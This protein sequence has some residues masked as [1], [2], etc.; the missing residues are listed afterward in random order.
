MRKFF[1]PKTHRDI[2]RFLSSDA[3]KRQKQQDLA[4][5]KGTAA[6]GNNGPASP[7]A[8]G[9]TAAA[10]AEGTEAAETTKVAGAL[11]ESSKAGSNDKDDSSKILFDWFEGFST[12]LI[13]G[14]LAA[15]AASD[16]LNTN[17]TTTRVLNI[18]D[19]VL[20][21]FFTFE[22]G[23]R[24]GSMGSRMLGHDRWLLIDLLTVILSLTGVI[25]SFT[26]F[27]SDAV[28]FTGLRSIRLFKPLTTLR[29]ITR[30][31]V[32]FVA[33]ARAIETLVDIVLL[34]IVFLVIFGV[35]GVSQYNRRLRN[36]C[37][38]KDYF[39]ARVGQVFNG[40]AFTDSLITEVAAAPNTRTLGTA[41]VTAIPNNASITTTTAAPGST[42]S[43]FLTLVQ[44]Q[45]QYNAAGHAAD[46]FVKLS[47][48]EQQV[49][50]DL[51]P[52]F[53]WA[54]YEARSAQFIV[55]ELRAA[56]AAYAAAGAARTEAVQRM[57]ANGT[58]DV[59]RGTLTVL[60]PFGIVPVSVVATNNTVNGSI[61]TNTT[62]VTFSLRSFDAA[63]PWNDA[64]ILPQGVFRTAV[65][66]SAA[67]PSATSATTTTLS[68][69]VLTL[70]SA[71]LVASD[72]LS[73]FHWLAAF[74]PELGDAPHAGA[75]N[76][77]NLVAT[78]PAKLKASLSFRHADSVMTNIL[79]IAPRRV[80]RGPT[81]T[82]AGRAA[83]L[84]PEGAQTLPPPPPRP[85]IA[86]SGGSTLAAAFAILTSALW[87]NTSSTDAFLNRSVAYVINTTSATR[88]GLPQPTQLGLPTSIYLESDLS[89]NRAVEIVRRFIFNETVP[90][91]LVN[92]SVLGRITD[93]LNETW[94]RR[95]ASPSS[96]S[97][98]V[99]PWPMINPQSSAA[100]NLAQRMANDAG[101]IAEGDLF[102]TDRYF[103]NDVIFTGAFVLYGDSGGSPQLNSSGITF[104]NLSFMVYNTSRF[105]A[106]NLTG[107][108]TNASSA[109]TPFELLGMVPPPT[110]P[111]V[112]INGT[113][114]TTF[115][116]TST[117]TPTST[118][119]AT[120]T[121]P[122]I[123]GL[124]PSAPPPATTVAPAV[125]V[126][127]L[128]F[129]RDTRLI[130]LMV[131]GGI[132][133]LLRNLSVAWNTTT[134]TIDNP[135]LPLARTLPPSGVWWRGVPN[136]TIGA[137]PD[138][139]FGVPIPRSLNVTKRLPIPNATVA[140]P[141]LTAVA[142][143]ITAAHNRLLSAITSGSFSSYLSTLLSPKTIIDN[144]LPRFIDGVQG[145]SSK[146]NDTLTLPQ[147]LS[148]VGNGSSAAAVL[149]VPNGTMF[150]NRALYRL[151][152][153]PGTF[154]DSDSRKAAA[155]ETA[156]HA[157]DSWWSDDADRVRRCVWRLG[158]FWWRMQ[159]AVWRADGTFVRW[160]G[161]PV[162][163]PA[164]QASLV[165]TTITT[166]TTT[167]AP[168]STISP[169]VSS[170]RAPVRNKNP[171]DEPFEPSKYIVAP[172]E[173]ALATLEVFIS[174]LPGVDYDETHYESYDQWLAS[175]LGCIW[176]PPTNASLAPIVVQTRTSA[177]TTVTQ[178]VSQSTTVTITST[179][180]GTNTSTGTATTTFTSTTVTSTATG[181]VAPTTTP[182][183]PPLPYV[184]VAAF[185]NVSGAWLPQNEI[186]V[187]LIDPL[188]ATILPLNMSL[189]L[190]QPFVTSLQSGTVSSA[191]TYENN[192]A[193]MASAPSWLLSSWRNQGCNN[194]DALL[195]AGYK[196]PFAYQCIEVGNPF[197][198]VIGFDNLLQ[199]MLVVF[200]STTFETWYDVAGMLSDSVDGTATLYFVCIVVIGAL[201]IMNLAV[202]Q[203][204]VTFIEATDAEMERV[205][206]ENMLIT[207][208]TVPWYRQ[209]YQR[210]HRAFQA[211]VKADKL[212]QTE[213]HTSTDAERRRRRLL[214]HEDAGDD[215]DDDESGS[216]DDDDDDEEAKQ[217]RYEI[218]IERKKM[219][220]REEQQQ[221]EYRDATSRNRER[222]G[223]EMK[224]RQRSGT[225]ATALG[226]PQDEG[227]IGRGPSGAAAL[228]PRAA[229]FET[230]RSLKEIEDEQLRKQQ[231]ADAANRKKTFTIEY[232]RTVVHSFFLSRY[233]K[234][235]TSTMIVF[236]ITVMGSYYYRMEEDPAYQFYVIGN[237]VSTSLF[238]LELLLRWFGFGFFGFFSRLVNIME[239]IVVALSWL[240]TFSDALN[241]PV[242]RTLRLLRFFL[243][244]RAFP[245]LYRWVIVI[246]LSLKSTVVLL[247]ISS[248]ALFLAA[249]FG[250]QLFGGTFCNLGDPN[251]ERVDNSVATCMNRPR[252]NY[253]SIYIALLTA[254]RIMTSQNW[255]EILYVSV[256]AKGAASAL[257]YIVWLLLSNRV[258][259]NLIIAIILKAKTDVEELEE[260][261]KVQ[262][263]RLE[264]ELHE[265]RLQSNDKYESE[266]RKEIE[267]QRAKADAVFAQIE[268]RL[269]RKKH[270]SGGSADGQDDTEEPS[271]LIALVSEHARAN[272]A[273][274]FQ[275]S[276]FQKFFLRIVTHSYFE[277]VMSIVVIVSSV[278]MV[279]EDPIAAPDTRVATVLSQVDV[280]SNLI[281]FAELVLKVSAFGFVMGKH[282]YLRR[283]VWNRVDFFVLIC[284]ATGTILDFVSDVPGLA[285]LRS[286]RGL[287]TL[288]ALRP[289][290][291]I[292]NSEGIRIVISTLVNSV[293]PLRNLIII[294]LGVFMLFGIL[295][296]QLFAGTFWKCTEMRFITKIDCEAA[297][298]DWVIPR[299]NFDNLYN[300]YVTLFTMSNL[301]EWSTVMLDGIDSV[302]PSMD[303]VVNNN[304]MAAFYF[305]FFIMVGSFFF[306]NFFTSILID[307]YQAER[308]KPIKVTDEDGDGATAAVTRPKGDTLF[309]TATQAQWIRTQ[310]LLLR[311]V[312][313][314]DYD[315]DS[316][317]NAAPGGGGPTLGA[318]T[319]A[320][321]TR[322]RWIVRHPL[323]DVSVY[324]CI[325]VNF[326]VMAADRY[327]KSASMALLLS[328]SNAG[329]AV[330]FTIECLARLY[331][332]SFK[333]Y[334]S[335]SWNR[336]DAVIVLMSVMSL[337]F[338][339]AL[340]STTFVS[341]FRTI[342]ILRMLRLL[343]RSVRL[344][345]VIKRFILALAS[346]KNIGAVVLLQFFI[347]GITGMKLFGRLRWGPVFNHNGNFA[348]LTDAWILLL[349]A[350][351][352][353]QWTPLMDAASATDV[354]E[355]T[356]QLGD[357]GSPV[358]AQLFFIVF[359][360]MASFVMLNL[361]VAVVLESFQKG[362]SEQSLV[363]PWD[364]AQLLQL[365]LRFDPEC[366][367][368]MQS[369]YLLTFLRSI[370]RA[371]PLGMSGINPRH[372]LK[373]EL[374]WMECMQLPEYGGLVELQDVLQ[375]L[376]YRY[377]RFGSHPEG[378]IQPNLPEHKRRRL[379]HKADLKF[380]R[381]D[382]DLGVVAT[383][384]PFYVHMRL[385]AMILEAFWDQ[386]QQRLRRRKKLASIRDI[387]LSEKRL[388]AAIKNATSTGG[389]ANQLLVAAKSHFVKTNSTG[390]LPAATGGPALSSD[391]NATARDGGSTSSP[392]STIGA[393]S[394]TD[395]DPD[396]MRKHVPPAALQNAAPALQA[397]SDA[398][399]RSKEAVV[400]ATAAAVSPGMED[401]EFGDWIDDGPGARNA[402][403]AGGS[404][405]PPQP[406]TDLTLA[407][408]P[409]AAA[410]LRRGVAWNP[411]NEADE[412][413]DNDTHARRPL[414]DA[415]TVPP[416]NRRP[417]DHPGNFQVPFETLR[418]VTSRGG[419]MAT[420]DDYWNALVQQGPRSSEPPSHRVTGGV[421]TAQAA[422]AP[423]ELQQDR[424]GPLKALKCQPRDA[425]PSLSRM[426]ALREL[427]PLSAV[428]S[429][430]SPT[431]TAGQP[432]STHHTTERELRAAVASLMTSGRTLTNGEATRLG[433]LLQ[434]R[435]PPPLTP[436]ER[437]RRAIEAAA[438]AESPTAPRTRRDTI[439]G[440]AHSKSGNRLDDD[441]RPKSRP[442]ISW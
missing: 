404:R 258:L 69:G 33:L 441:T 35:G 43:T 408:V 8:D 137:L 367:L 143:N 387:I 48:Y 410:G 438:A 149:G 354:P 254:F 23:V 175:V 242:V 126:D 308:V 293:V 180:T 2:E 283:D 111:S 360:I 322:V 110:G 22:F 248:F 281:F 106:V 164:T 200:I 208:T 134:L 417:I 374:I 172:N 230:Q 296:V 260:I 174:E 241:L 121:M 133:E 323:F 405:R 287:R 195:L 381:A 185:D 5:Q 316:G 342:R 165:A 26:A 187:T 311:F 400:A 371:S 370:P 105:T 425:P 393:V 346:L 190:F 216:D 373:N 189:T 402:A 114:T 56:L 81:L 369:K 298:A 236:N 245:G 53:K 235:V 439:L 158:W 272:P 376:C 45:V 19:I 219:R 98:P 243:L 201:F 368:R 171:V 416:T 353:G 294:I 392:H 352:G 278:C 396:M 340:A 74:L 304:P 302:G 47:D 139:A 262:R 7:T 269:R 42:A 3:W 203:L 76:M 364:S 39:S 96:S 193:Q 401:D 71:S 326:L 129:R 383:K 432:T 202:A 277:N 18:V 415:P 238:S 280:M 224:T 204:T 31:R 92:I 282:T 327:P 309:L 228:L 251:D 318:A 162:M 116:T 70:P 144:S 100:T 299:R 30:A 361:F 115:T 44:N 6:L 167:T 176:T 118:G 138:W 130:F 407:P 406:L 437:V 331:A 375:A 146:S 222:F 259:V 314:I 427:D 355:C 141:L 389:S 351:T 271:T 120:T 188:G 4:D 166:T 38:N 131:N 159:V 273:G 413:D 249:C 431:G 51:L 199:A 330:V 103:I 119:T 179:S 426:P 268:G 335:H 303:P 12:F 394:T 197:G 286:I 64:A 168:N 344:Q 329:F 398:S 77:T 356:P 359:V 232:Y 148:Q 341:F 156:A 50:A 25:V 82:T 66:T 349:R 155:A 306:V 183:P 37:V 422:T 87:A 163:D 93:L 257:Y 264:T 211:R 94:W 207:S 336:F 267:A 132:E 198:G 343:R 333:I 142:Y 151:S 380:R 86:D 123:F 225:T 215:D 196:C 289:L 223:F 125:P 75:L 128:A 32:L 363:A 300:A 113:A 362:G 89:D 442:N 332:E 256:Q 339:Y 41:P 428:L 80:N 15:F 184:A 90:L 418:G 424:F 127:V 231:E 72:V 97:H 95:T 1:F 140:F 266:K 250:M 150:G 177:T 436:A 78:T 328:A 220:L 305:I 213:E 423:R 178:T 152:Q 276:T 301:D 253:D 17:P 240:D 434:Q 212:A 210:V 27:N 234:A 60:W 334:F 274:A 239:L 24:I 411:D 270:M 429:G 288:R 122:N 312:P 186:S 292:T 372:R 61:P 40:T 377:F 54:K 206:I 88:S 409:R 28:S 382:R 246:K 414:L 91:A 321:R 182:A 317:G 435:E 209:L 433:A 55:S 58:A 284:S 63:V 36:R 73:A 108:L 255:D 358:L 117:G 65:P 320:M 290:R 29:S 147:L 337:V 275:P 345:V 297:G 391:A 124:I 295:G 9:E 378:V 84:P 419:A 384:N 194:V 420:D 261:H 13:V 247:V 10:A 170:Q 403:A 285:A 104:K 34:F 173:T 279:F 350:S 388:E 386:R 169:M 397:S 390:S 85:W 310:R 347:F 181:T 421:V 291:V 157:A 366:T 135:A 307:A 191:A 365:W 109:N 161:P 154:A 315:D 263:A 102:G 153:D 214:L 11:L 46:A 348:S 99:D 319:S 68:P 217:L 83:S 440:D 112:I 136:S 21:G 233:G 20:T 395:D 52:A 59:G 430:S 338:E 49:Y 62:N 313:D 218:D 252:A 227:T 101:H 205:R 357:C 412:D 192:L 226:T 221:V 324:C 79:S 14:S 107:I 399:Q 229:T 237:Y 160:S 265:L 67:A 145:L 57:L 16:P 325:T 244:L 385:A 379:A